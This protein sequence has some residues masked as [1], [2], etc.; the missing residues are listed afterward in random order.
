MRNRT[1]R[2]TNTALVAATALSTALIAGVPATAQPEEPGSASDA[3]QRLRELSREAEVVTEDFKKVQ[4]DHAARQ[5]ELDASTAAAHRAD[6]AAEQARREE[7][8]FRGEVDQLTAASYQGARMNTLSALLTAESPESFLDRASALDAL[9]RDNNQAVHAVVTA[10]RR[11]ESAQRRAAEERARAARA[12]AE[13]ARLQQEFAVRKDEMDARV[14]EVKE[15]YDQ[16][17]AQ[18][19]EALSGDDTDV[20]P[21]SG[22]GTAIAAVNAALSKQGSPYVWGAK[23]PNQFDCSGLVQWSFEQAGLSLPASTR[24]Q[25]ST[26]TSVTESQLQPGDVIFFYD[27]ASHNG[28]YI[29]GGNVVHA[30]TEGQNVKV[31]K[32]DYIG[33]VHS[34]RRMTG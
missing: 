19:Q 4:D 14:A 28:I 30:P 1:T 31:E 11:A 34:I 27:S 2:T 9:A 25:V 33:D 5:R 26:G 7:E 3:A 8:R 23:G 20:G 22:S 32:Y 16:L 10:T 18:E 6:Q 13:A 21:V 17:S 12:E 15:Q 24:T 29:G